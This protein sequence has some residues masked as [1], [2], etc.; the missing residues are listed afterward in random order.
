MTHPV[1]ITRL[2]RLF[3]G[4]VDRRELSDSLFLPPSLSLPGFSWGGEEQGKG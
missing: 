2:Q 1:G 3:I 4:P